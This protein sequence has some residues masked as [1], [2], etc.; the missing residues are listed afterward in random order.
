MF[1]SEAILLDLSRARPHSITTLELIAGILLAALLLAALRGRTTAPRT[2]I[3]VSPPNG[4]S[5]Y[6]AAT[7]ARNTLT[8]RRRPTRD[9]GA[10]TAVP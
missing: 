5:R 9:G 7:A 1:I 10:P 4:A 6:S 3:R 8:S 2:T